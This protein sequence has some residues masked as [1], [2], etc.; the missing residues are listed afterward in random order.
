MV[1]VQD[2]EVPVQAKEEAGKL[3]GLHI[4]TGHEEDSYLQGENE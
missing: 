3:V 2:I 4:R 1:P